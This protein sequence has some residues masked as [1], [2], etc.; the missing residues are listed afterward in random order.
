MASETRR[1]VDDHVFEASTE[2]LVEIEVNEEADTFA[3]V[4]E[5]FHE[6]LVAVGEYDVLV[7]DMEEE[8][9]TVND[10]VQEAVN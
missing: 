3:D 7:G 5:E 9:K 10:D 4:E 6:K 8:E 1:A 2:L